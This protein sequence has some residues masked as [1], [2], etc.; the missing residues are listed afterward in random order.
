MITVIYAH[1]PLARTVFIHV[2]NAKFGGA[3]Q[4]A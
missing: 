1:V 2:Y 3:G 4:T